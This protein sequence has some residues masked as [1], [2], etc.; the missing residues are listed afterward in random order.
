MKRRRRE[1]GNEA[2]LSTRLVVGTETGASIFSH[3][4]NVRCFCYQ[5]GNHESSS[6]WRPP[7]Q[8]FPPAGYVLPAS[9]PGRRPGIR[10]AV[11]RGRRSET[12]FGRGERPR[13]SHPT[14]CATSALDK[15]K[16]GELT[17]ATLLRLASQA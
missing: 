11:S 9:L 12:T 4:R 3:L 8:G 16:K 1:R 13:T 17:A 10:M 5:W 2:S 7:V 15:W 6:T 14:Y